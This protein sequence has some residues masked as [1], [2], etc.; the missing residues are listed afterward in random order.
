MFYWVALLIVLA[1]VDGIFAFGHV[2]S[3]GVSAA[4]VLFAIFIL[5]L[6]VSLIFGAMKGRRTY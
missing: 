1:I 3:A 6:I 5:A 2:I 4:Q